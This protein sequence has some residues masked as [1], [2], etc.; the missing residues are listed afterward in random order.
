MGWLGEPRRL[1]NRIWW[2]R[3]LRKEEAPKV[4]VSIRGGLL[5]QH[6]VVSG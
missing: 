5:L 3:V 1:I 4:G 6:P 2:A